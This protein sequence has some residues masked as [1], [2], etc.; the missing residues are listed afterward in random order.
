MKARGV[1]NIHQ[2]HQSANSDIDLKPKQPEILTMAR[3]NYLILT[4]D[5]GGIRGVISALLIQQLDAELDFLKR[6]NLFAGTSTGGLIAL[7]LAGGVPIDRIVDIYMTRGAEVFKPYASFSPQPPPSLT[8]V[9]PQAALLPVD[10]LHVKYTDQGL[11]KI[12]KQTFPSDKMLSELTRKV[13][14]TSLDLYDTQRKA[15][16]PVSLTNLAGSK[17]SDIKVLDAALSTCGAPVY[18]P[19]HIFTHNGQKRAL[20]DGGVYANNPSMLAAA[21]T[22]SSG[23]LKRRG[24]AFE[25]IKLLSLGTGFTLDGMPPKL[26]LPAAWY[27]VLAWMSPLTLPP[28]PQ[29]PLLPLLMDSVADIDTFQCKQI[30]GNNFRRGNVQLQQPIDLDDY[31]K[32]GLLKAWTEAYMASAEWDEIK[33]WIGNEFI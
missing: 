23:T 25:D 17:T 22:I 10:L 27:G 24:L 12:V 2:D 8:K 7:G 14:V 16:Q 20:V 28:T 13:L 21:T 9:Y 31:Q 29:F 33:E 19:P 11:S 32:V 18:F 3:A 15:W 5:G 1:C 4:C 30:L 26:M 6:V